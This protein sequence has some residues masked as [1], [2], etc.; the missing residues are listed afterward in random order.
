M[1]N[2]IHLIGCLLFCCFIQ[3]VS[4]ETWTSSLWSC[5]KTSGTSNIEESDRLDYN[6]VTILN[7]AN[8][9]TYFRCPVNIR[10]DKAITKIQ[11]DIYADTAINVI[12]LTPNDPN[13]VYSL[14]ICSLTIQNSPGGSDTVSLVPAKSVPWGN[15]D[16]LKVSNPT[17]QSPLSGSAQSA[18]L[19]CRTP[20]YADI[21]RFFGL[22]ITY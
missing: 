19:W 11:V 14:P 15:Y 18:V 4:A 10:S 9:L 21:T 13:I 2:K 16:Q 8:K 5:E 12:N 1:K 7:D 6:R 17:L 3:G 22:R 20:Y